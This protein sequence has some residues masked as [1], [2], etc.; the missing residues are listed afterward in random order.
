MFI[1][2]HASGYYH[3]HFRAE[4]GKWK[5]VAAKT[6]KKSAAN[7]FFAD[8]KQTSRKKGPFPIFLLEYRD[9]YLAFSVTNHS[10]QTTARIR[11]VLQHFTALFQD[12]PLHIISPQQIEAYKA[13]R[14]GK[15]SAVTVNIELR[16]LKSFFSTAVKW[17]MIQQNPFHAV[18]M[19][20]LP[21]RKPAYLSADDIK[22]LL[23]VITMRWLKDLILFDLNTGLRR[24]ELINLHWQDVDLASSV[25]LVRNTDTFTTMSRTERAVPLNSQAREI[26]ERLPRRSH[27][28]FINSSGRKLLGKY[29]SECF[30][31][32]VIRAGIN[33]KIHW[34]SIRHS[35]ASFAVKQNI[36]IYHLQKILGHSSISVTMGYAHL[37]SRDLHDAV[38]RLIIPINKN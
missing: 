34:H 3:V 32:A 17:S 13:N 12:L 37:V 10:P 22:S 19:V 7:N 33:P 15:V 30:R 20:R 29:V 26:L 36:D 28:V 27:Y 2:K 21:E 1:N 8:F 24:G 31:E 4:D 23:G 11:Y 25:I 16:T 5:S 6:K 9:K 14:L 35:F 38:D 18:K